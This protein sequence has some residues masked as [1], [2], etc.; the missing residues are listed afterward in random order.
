MREHAEAYICDN[1]AIWHANADSTGI[2]DQRRLIE[3]TSVERSFDVDCGPDAEHCVT[4]S[5][6]RCDACGTT[7]AGS[8]HRAWVEV[9][10]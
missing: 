2:E 10:S 8:R 4:F 1:C 6:S 7:L 3:V 9:A 5:R